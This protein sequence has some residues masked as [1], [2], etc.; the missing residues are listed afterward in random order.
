[1][2]LVN[3]TTQE[4]PQQTEPLVFLW[5]VRRH[6][7]LLRDLSSKSATFGAFGKHWHLD[8][9][10]YEQNNAKAFSV[11]LCAEVADGTPRCFHMI[12]RK[13][14][15]GPDLARFLEMI[16]LVQ[17][18][19]QEP[20]EDSTVLHL[21]THQTPLLNYGVFPRLFGDSTR[22]DVT[23]I[24]GGQEMPAHSAVLLSDRAGPYF[25]AF[26]AHPFKESRDGKVHITG[27]AHN[28]FKAIL[29]YIYTGRTTVDGVLGLCELYCAAERFQVAT[30]LPYIQ[31]ELLLS[32]RVAVQPNPALLLTLIQQMKAFPALSD[33][34]RICV[35]AIL[36]DWATAKASE[37]WR[38]VV[39]GAEIQDFIEA[40]LDQAAVLY[41]Q[42]TV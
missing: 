28:I 35:K 34:V 24:I 11:Y 13:E 6:R 41:Q 29:E 1:M 8:C 7:T 42:A 12:I 30:Q 14:L 32:L 31:A 25:A 21:F 26:L 22:S 9:R 27:V 16:P 5:S 3:A 18:N 4:Q 33:V 36:M 19:G 38:A 37:S 40:F 2:A 39:T 10:Q 20:A 23:F 17:D 15:F